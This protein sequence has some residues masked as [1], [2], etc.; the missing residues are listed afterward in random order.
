MNMNRQKIQEG[1]FQK[2]PQWYPEEE[3]NPQTIFEKNARN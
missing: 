3:K 2:N 1:L